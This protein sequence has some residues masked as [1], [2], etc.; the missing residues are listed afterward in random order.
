MTK[1]YKCHDC[2]LLFSVKE[3]PDTPPPTCPY[4]NSKNVSVTPDIIS[5]SKEEMKWHQ[6]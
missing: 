6:S 2:A 1:K 3:A 5:V 4:C